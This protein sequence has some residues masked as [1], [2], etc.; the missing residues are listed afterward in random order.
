M[1]TIDLLPAEHRRAERTAPAKFLATVGLVALFFS[2]ASACAYV[3]FGVVGGARSDVENA[4]EIHE[5][6]KPMAAYCD[7]LEK[8][9]KEYTARM[10]HIRDFSSSRVLWTKKIDQLAS[11]VDS[12]EQEDRHTVWMQE[13][14]VA[15]NDARSRGLRIKGKSATARL[16]RLSDF[17]SDLK[18]PPFFTE[19][20]GIS[21]PEGKVVHDDDFEP[22][23]AWEFEA[24]LTLEDPNPQTKAAAKPAP[25]PRK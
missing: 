5:S 19:F 12:P 7:T 22:S 21:V 2:T 20:N 6:K 16:K 24:S 10:D 4:K 25:A 23:A 13:L 8:E 15:M 18:T 11:L 3:W 1:I 14:N 9:K 17:N